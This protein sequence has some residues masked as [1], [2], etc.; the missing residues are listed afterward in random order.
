MRMQLVAGAL[1]LIGGAR[2]MEAQDL[3][4]RIAASRAARVSFTFAAKPGLCG[5]GDNINFGSRHRDADDDGTVCSDGPVRVTLDQNAGA[6]TRVKMTVGGHAPTGAD[7][8][9]DVAP[10]DAADWLLALAAR[11]EGRASEEAVMPA[12]VAKDVV[13]WPRL[14]AMAKDHDLREG[15]RKQAIFWLGQ[16][17]ADQA[18]GPLEDIVNEDPDHEVKETALFAL[19]Q[20][21]NDHAIDVLIRVAR[22]NPDRQLR[23]TAFFWLGQSEDPRGIALFEQVL[24][25]R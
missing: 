8:L 12:A 24:A 1:L 13:V 18:V 5:C 22:S 3:A 10:A 11:G 6:V 14:V 23:R 4:G 17:A 9:G 21:H 19:S 2:G 25:G 15:T 7:D 20:Q 16:Q